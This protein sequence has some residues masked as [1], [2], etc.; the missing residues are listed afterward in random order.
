[1]KL[2]IYDHCPYCVKAR[3]IFGIK[4]IN[5]ELITLLNDDEAT[6]ISMIGQ[7]LVPILELEDGSYMPESLDI[8]H[9]IDNN[10]GDKKS[11]NS[12]IRPEISQW[13]ND[14]RE[15]I[16][17]LAMPRWAK[18]DLEEFKTQEAIDYFTKKKEVM[19]GS[20]EDNLKSSSDLIKI[21]NQHLEDLEI[22]IKSDKAVNGEF[23][24]DDIHLFAALRSLS[25]VKGLKFPNR[26]KI[27][28]D[29]MAK[30]CDIPL[31]FNLAC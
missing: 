8:I 6:P 31:H 23:S 21:T 2:Y 1:M 15:Y 12:K 22:L 16:Y 30:A 10:Y 27:Y 18:S 4:N 24:E 3:M 14:S 29:N 5:F 28:M 11:L 17:R 13:L 9:Y 7:K 26:V 20:F 25:I 19:I